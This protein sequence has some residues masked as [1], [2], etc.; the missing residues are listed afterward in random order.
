[1]HK[2]F[3]FVILLPISCTAGEFDN[4]STLLIKLN[5]QF[6]Q[7]QNAIN[8]FYAPRPLQNLGNT[9]YMNSVI[10]GM[11]AITP[12]TNFLLD[13]AGQYAP[14]SLAQSYIQLINGLRI[15]KYQI[16]L[17]RFAKITDNIMQR[18]SGICGS[19]AQQDAQEF[20]IRLLYNLGKT[21][22]P[23]I[24]QTISNQIMISIDRYIKCDGNIQNPR[25][26]NEPMLIMP[27]R[28]PTSG[29]LLPGNLPDII[30]TYFSSEI[31]TYA[32][33]ET[34]RPQ[35]CLKK[36][37]IT[38]L[39]NILLL[40]VARF[41]IDLTR[42]QENYALAIETPLEFDM[43]DTQSDSFLPPEYAAPFLSRSKY[44][45]IATLVHLGTIYGGHYIA[46][47]RNELNNW[48]YCSDS[49]IKQA[50]VDD[51]L[52]NSKHGYIYIYQRINT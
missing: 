27:V 42:A 36:E 33:P 37:Y 10:Q 30:K 32:P 8:A 21:T 5:D 22:T 31:I 28:N 49:Y 12:L 16:A 34:G 9:C 1:M 11:Y 14:N 13:K 26:S 29:A 7:L 18:S 17:Q 23:E 43:A 51:V 41:D 3:V 20:F 46:Y 39:P 40:N 44:R 25:S 24:G 19:G 2:Q 52:E 15:N 45:L 38:H 48:Y 4:L 50:S 47:V 35:L 6:K